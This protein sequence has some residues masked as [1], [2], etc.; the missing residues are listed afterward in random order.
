MGDIQSV[1]GLL[2]VHHCVNSHLKKK[3]YE[4]AQNTKQCGYVFHA[5]VKLI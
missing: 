3:G 4:A 5:I 2:L 1:F